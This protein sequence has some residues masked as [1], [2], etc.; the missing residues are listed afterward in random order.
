V[1]KPGNIDCM[2]VNYM[3]DGTLKEKPH[4][5]AFHK[6][7]NAVIGNGDTIRAVKIPNVHA[8]LRSVRPTRVPPNLETFKGKRVRSN[9]RRAAGGPAMVFLRWFCLGEAPAAGR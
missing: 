1:P 9:P 3:E 2:A 7:S 6:M 4:I 5:N 8:V